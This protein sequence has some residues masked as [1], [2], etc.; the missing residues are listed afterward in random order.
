MERVVE[1]SDDRVRQAH[2]AVT[3]TFISEM[4]APLLGIVVGVRTLVFL[5]FLS[6]LPAFSNAQPSAKQKK[7]QLQQQMKKLQDEIKLMEAALKKTSAKKEQ[8]L[9]EIQALQTKIKTREKL[10][11]SYSNQVQNLDESISETASDIETKAAQ[12]EKMKADYA[13]MLRKSYASLSLQNELVFFLSSSSFSDAVLRYH[14]MLKV[15]EYRREQARQLQQLI[16]DLN[17]KEND[18]KEDKDEKVSLL[19]RQTAQKSELLKEKQEKDQVLADLSEK[20]KKLRQHVAEKN[21]AAQQ[22]NNKIQAIIEEEIK[23][24][25]KKAEEQAR[26]KKAANTTAVSVSKKTNETMPLTPEEQA[27]SKDFSNNQGKLPWPVERGNIVG[28]FGKHEHP[29]IKGVMIENNGVDIKT[30][31]GSDARA[32]FGGLVVSVFYMPTTQNCIIVKHGEYFTVYSNIETVTVKPN[33]TITTKQVIGK[34][35]TDKGEDMTKVHLEIWKGK[36]KMD[37]EGWLVKK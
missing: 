2:A 15:E 7:E 29:Q 32:V 36:D 24:A 30:A 8:N 18:L 9:D 35:H 17:E 1:R 23:Q 22:L 4:V 6:L 31:P 12:V 16:A 25:K 27:L 28:Q 33:Q 37:P 14:Y 11:G 13:D 10:I 34:L 21:K 19:Q 26:K 3:R 5:L 20:E